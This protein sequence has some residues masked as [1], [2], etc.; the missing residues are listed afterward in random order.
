[1]KSTLSLSLITC[2]VAL[3]VAAQETA[4]RPGPIYQ[5]VARE[6]ARLVNE[7]SATRTVQQAKTSRKSDW[8]NVKKIKPNTEIT[9]LIVRDSAPEKRYFVSADDSEL[10]F[11][12]SKQGPPERV[13]KAD[14][15]EIRRPGLGADGGGTLGALAGLFAGDFIGWAATRNCV[16]DDPG[17]GVHPGLFLGGVIGGVAG[18]ITLKDAFSLLIYHAP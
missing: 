2:L 10:T 7:Q 16:C 6:A 9:T 8:S 4:L 14:V 11:K 18:A 12:S 1:M 5:A 13:A 15:G 17:I 3:P